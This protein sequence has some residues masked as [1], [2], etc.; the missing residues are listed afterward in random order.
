MVWAAISCHPD[1]LADAPAHFK[2]DVDI[3]SQALRHCQRAEDVLPHIGSE[4][5]NNPA[6]FQKLAT[7]AVTR[8]PFCASYF[9]RAVKQERSFLR[10][11]LLL[12]SKDDKE[13][14]RPVWVLN[15]DVLEDD[16]LYRQMVIDYLKMGPIFLQWQLMAEFLHDREIVELLINCNPDTFK[17]LDVTLRQDNA[18]ARH[19]VAKRG[20]LLEYVGDALRDDFELVSIAVK[21][22]GMALRYASERLRNNPHIVTAALQSKGE[23]LKYA[24]KWMCSDPSFAR[25][26]VSRQSPGHDIE[27]YLP[28][29]FYGVK[30]LMMEAVERDYEN[31]RLVSPALRDDDELVRMVLKHHGEQLE[32]ASNR[33][34]GDRDV[35]RL[36]VASEGKA[37]EHA[38]E[39]LRA[40]PDVVE[41]ALRNDGMALQY[42]HTQLR[43]RT[44]LVAIAVQQNGL[45][46]EFAP[47]GLRSDKPL[48]TLAL[49]NNGEALRFAAP[50][51]WDDPDI[52]AAAVASIGPVAVENIRLDIAAGMQNNTAKS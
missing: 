22:D 27:S 24:P 12:A 46:L 19:A 36:A 18:L 40:D 50:S 5:T 37:L 1:A 35:V 43:T 47:A 33:L 11:L 7:L 28:R 32:H 29:F 34:R 6:I 48:V 42:V 49:H 26:A 44:Q 9:T 16:Q 15:S 8:D 31:F 45:A 13:N 52:I 38:D 2:N 41:L 30:P 39:S 25:L 20:T 21:S 4:L 3:V 14:Y 10:E 51:L 23:A 17:Y